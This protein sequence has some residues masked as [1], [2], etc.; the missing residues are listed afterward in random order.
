MGVIIIIFSFLFSE[1]QY[2]AAGWLDSIETTLVANEKSKGLN[3]N[4][5][6]DRGFDDISIDAWDKPKDNIQG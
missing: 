5:G 6:C 2:V 1:H 3:L 4:V